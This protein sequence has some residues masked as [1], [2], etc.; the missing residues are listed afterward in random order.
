MT[1]P[2]KAGA[3]IAFEDPQGAV[4][5]PQDLVTLIQGIGTAALTA[6]AVGIGIG[7]RFHD[8]IEAKQVER[9]HRSIGH[10]RNP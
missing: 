8:R 7:S 9:L 2:I 6:K 3:D 4:V 5:V 1:D 10:G